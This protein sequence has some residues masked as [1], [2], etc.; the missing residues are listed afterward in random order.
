MMLGWTIKQFIIGGMFNERITE[1]GGMS[2]EIRERFAW[3]GYKYIYVDNALAK[4]MIRSS[5]KGKRPS[6]IRMK[7]LISK[8]EL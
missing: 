6:I 4:Q 2:Q 1:Y 3:Q 5:L 8:L 7:N